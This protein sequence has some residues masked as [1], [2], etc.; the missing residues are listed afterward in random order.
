[1]KNRLLIIEDDKTVRENIVTILTEEGFKVFSADNGYDGIEL[2]KDENPD[3]IICDV[4]MEGLNGFDVLTLVRRTI[5]R[6]APFIFLTAKTDIA[7]LRK[8]MELGA[9]DYLHKP[10]KTKELLNAINTRLTKIEQTEAYFADKLKLNQKENSAER[11]YLY[12]DKILIK[13]EGK[14][15]FIQI[16]NI[17]AISAENQYSKIMMGGKKVFHLKKALSTWENILP[18]NYFKRIH[19]STIVN[20]EYIEAIDNWFKNSLKVKIEGISE[21]YI[22]SR[23]YASKFLKP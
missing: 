2:I 23:R 16:K 3:L 19:R 20:T 13:N 22:V 6:P 17:K 7:D 14:P 18:E 8:G 4:M 12:N 15:E 11:R 5:D 1:M 10:F 9:D 21:D